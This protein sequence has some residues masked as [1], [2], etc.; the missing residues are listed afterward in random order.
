MASRGRHKART[1][2][3]QGVYG[4]LPPPSQHRNQSVPVW[5]PPLGNGSLPQLD[6]PGV[7]PPGGLT[8]KWLAGRNREA[9]ARLPNRRALGPLAPRRLRPPPARPM[10]TAPMRA[11]LFAALVPLLVPARQEE[12]A[13][14]PASDT[15]AGDRAVPPEEAQ[16]ADSAG[17]TSEKSDE[18]PL[19]IGPAVREKIDSY[20]ALADYDMNGWISFREAHASMGHDRLTYAGYDKD[21][22]GRIRMDE[23][24]RRYMEILESGGGFEPPKPP[25]SPYLVPARNSEQLR[26]AFDVTADGK[27]EL[28]EVEQML[29][30]YQYSEVPAEVVFE[31]L[32][33]DESEALELDE[34]AM[35]AQLLQAPQ[36][37]LE[38]VEEARA[39]TAAS[40]EELFG[41]LEPRPEEAG[42]TLHPPRIPGP[43][44]PFRRLD[45]DNDGAVTVEELERLARPLTLSV[46]PGAM[47]A[48]LDQNEDGQ[49]D[50]DEFRGAM[51]RAVEK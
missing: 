25:D 40:I 3:S 47:L 19:E 33:V 45:L 34:L 42:G 29:A 49:L 13:A 44:P 4:H 46:R 21:A 17:E 5:D 51:S 15:A 32:D 11:L 6:R 50:R 39:A 41:G 38:N 7:E 18:P 23:F 30:L 28:F 8:D 12:T 1:A 14:P 48:A 35:L 2:C 36:P 26:N 10:L 37:S 31:K 22:D 9:A 24:E 16:P 27:L 43:V 20:F